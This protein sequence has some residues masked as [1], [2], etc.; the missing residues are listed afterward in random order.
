MQQDQ[1]TSSQVIART[2]LILRTLENYPQGLSISALARATAMP[3]TTVHRLVTSLIGE[4]LLSHNER[5][6]CLGP[7]LIRLAASAHTDVIAIARPALETL[8]RRTRETVELS[9]FRGTHA[10][11]LSQVPSDQELRV[12]SEVG[13]AF[14][15]H[16]SAHGKALL[17]DMSDKAVLQLLGPQ[18]EKRTSLSLETPEAI[19][20]DLIATRTQRYATDIEEHARGVCG[21]A[22]SLRTG[23][24]E[25]YALS[26]AVP[27]Q[28]FN[29]QR[30]RLLAALMQ[31]RAE[32]EAA[33][34]R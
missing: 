31:C 2:A 3:R 24:G 10:I 4:G 17:A 8:G 34:S 22:V 7:A 13:T 20:A 14:P 16:C 9:V 29:E 21:I 18:P 26:I 19:L 15:C 6:I 11:S 32:I 27:A 30:S 23:P 5:L 33:L 25:R 1:Q 12:V 28:R